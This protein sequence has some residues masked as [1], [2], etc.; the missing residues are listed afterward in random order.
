M[1]RAPHILVDLNG[2]SKVALTPFLMSKVPLQGCMYMAAVLVL[3][4]GYLAHK[5]GAPV[6]EKKGRSVAEVA[7]EVFHENHAGR[8]CILHP[9]PCTLHPAPCTLH[10]AP[11]T[12]HP[13]PL[14][15][16]L[17]P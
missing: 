5:K 10:P 7:H 1:S 2:L 4:Q 8:P 3:I 13:A 16:N 14:T 15:R 17:G 11:C 6:E 12:L 9:A